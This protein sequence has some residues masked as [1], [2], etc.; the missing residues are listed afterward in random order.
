VK[1][2][3][4]LFYPNLLFPPPNFHR[5]TLLS[6]PSVSRLPVS[7]TLSCK[8]NYKLFN[9]LRILWEWQEKAEIERHVDHVPLPVRFPPS[10]DDRQASPAALLL[11]CLAGLGFSHPRVPFY[12][13]RGFAGRVFRMTGGFI[14]QGVSLIHSNCREVFSLSL[15]LLLGVKTM[16]F[17]EHLDE[18]WRNSVWFDEGDD[19]DSTVRV[20]G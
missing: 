14:L 16:G 10:T 4:L 5:T 11:V 20:L 6:L 15:N 1:I 19:N 18:A 17:S 3:P 8:F 12:W 2:T 9:I 13:K 7:V